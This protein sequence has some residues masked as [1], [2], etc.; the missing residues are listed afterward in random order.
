[1]RVLASV[2]DHNA[3]SQSLVSRPMVDGKGFD[4]PCNMGTI[5]LQTKILVIPAAAPHT[6]IPL[7]DNQVFN[8]GAS[9]THQ[10]TTQIPKSWKVNIAR[11]DIRKDIIFG[12]ERQSPPLIS[13]EIECRL[14]IESGSIVPLC[15]F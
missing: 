1:M 15:E 12:T 7:S 10:T 5:K 8:L 14:S 13:V 6:P 9:E 3:D 11:Y 2:G 4:A